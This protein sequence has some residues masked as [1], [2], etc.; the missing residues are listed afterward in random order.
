MV[1]TKNLLLALFVIMIVVQT[2]FGVWL[3]TTDRL[4]LDPDVTCITKSFAVKQL[5]VSGKF[6]F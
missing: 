6:F 3:L 1:D 2:C 4:N 5:E